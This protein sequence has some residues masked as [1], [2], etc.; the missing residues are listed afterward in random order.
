MREQRR[1]DA[2]VDRRDEQVRPERPRFRR[3]GQEDRDPDESDVGRQRQQA[4][5]A[6]GVEAA[7][8]DRAGALELADQQAGDEEA[9][10]DE[11]DV[12]ADVAAGQERHPGVREEDGDDRDRPQPLDVGAE[13]APRLSFVRMIS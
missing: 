6:A 5:G 9:G 13:T 11:E 12:D 3:F 7:Q 8:G 10:D 1:G 2:G 4:F